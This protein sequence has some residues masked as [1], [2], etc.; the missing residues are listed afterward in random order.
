MPLAAAALALLLNSCSMGKFP[1]R[2]YQMGDKVSLGS[3][4]YTVFETQWLTQMGE[5]PTL[6]VPRHRFFLVRASVVNSGATEITLRTTTLS[7]VTPQACPG[8]TSEQM[9]LW[10]WANSNRS[11]IRLPSMPGNRIRT[12]CGPFENP[13]HADMSSK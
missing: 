11:C 1:V 13:D 9:A 8:R 6:R 5:E 2:T 4:I 3:F 12:C 7:T 10:S